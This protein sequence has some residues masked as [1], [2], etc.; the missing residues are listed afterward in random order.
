MAFYTFSV[1][2]FITI[3]T[4]LSSIQP[5]SL[6]CEIFLNAHIMEKIGGGNM[7]IHTEVEFN[8]L[9]L[10]AHMEKSGRWKY[11]DSWEGAFSLVKR[12]T[13]PGYP[14]FE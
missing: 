8:Q 5:I 4:L 12:E 11:V 7:E 13:G 14:P 3:A 6:Q 1:S 2:S 9:L 10:I